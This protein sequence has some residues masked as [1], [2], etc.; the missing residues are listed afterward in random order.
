M[1]EDT[2]SLDAA[3]I[4]KSTPDTPKI[5]NRLVQLIRMVKSTRQMW[6]NEIVCTQYSGPSCFL[7]DAQVYL[8]Y[9]SQ[10]TISINRYFSRTKDNI[11]STV[12]SLVQLTNTQGMTSAV[13]ISFNQLHAEVSYI[14][15]VTCH[16]T[17]FSNITSFS[18]FL[19]C[20]SADFFF[21]FPTPN[22]CRIISSN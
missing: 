11:G 3:Q 22:F 17:F 19:E 6:V 12:S 13:T 5:G 15:S 18:Y 1:L 14:I 2:N 10:Y 9:L 20:Q 8:Y 21:H 4:W 16:W 7:L